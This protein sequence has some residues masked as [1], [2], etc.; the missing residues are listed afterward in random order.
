MASSE[1]SLA[2][3]TCFD[4]IHITGEQSEISKAPGN[5]SLIWEE[6]EWMLQQ[7]RSEATSSRLAWRRWSTSTAA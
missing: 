4:E 6:R 7:E 5:A 1:T 3:R 2:H